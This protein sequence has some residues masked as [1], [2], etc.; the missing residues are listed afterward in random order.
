MNTSQAVERTVL[1][2]RV[3]THR[4]ALEGGVV[5]TPALLEAFL[6]RQ[7]VKSTTEDTVKRYRHALE[8]LYADLPPDKEIR[9][10]TLAQWRESLLERGYAP[11][12]VNV[13]VSAAN[14]LLSYLGRREL[15]LME[16]LEPQT[17]IRPELTRA[18]YLRL[19]GTARALG[20]RQLYL[21]IKLFAGTGLPVQALPD[22]TVE[23]VEAGSLV[24]TRGGERRGVPIPAC[25]RR[26]LLD[27]ARD[28][29][30][31][32][33][34]IFVTGSGKPLGRTN[35]SSGIRK[36]CADAQVPE[37]KGNP[38]CL[39]ALYQATRAGIEA[40]ISLLVEQTQERLMESE[41]PSIG[42]EEAP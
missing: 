15:Q 2:G 36:L 29:G 6:E 42:W 26:E 4:T 3:S 5:L 32:S 19:L 30:R 8:L 16:R 13:C 17:E 38:R 28:A 33:G 24:V 37:E 18:E 31:R 39:R 11:R 27:Y 41:Q 9:R 23:G 20:K 22:V 25:L 35:V 21:L 40:N 34:A 7:R 12:T 14:S 1:T 10:G